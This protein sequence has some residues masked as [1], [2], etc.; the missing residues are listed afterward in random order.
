MMIENDTFEIYRQKYAD[1]H[2][3]NNTWGKRLETL[4]RVIPDGF[5]FIQ[6]ER[7]LTWKQFDG[8][9]NRL[10]NLFL[11]LGIEKEDRI[12]IMGFNSIE[13]VE[14]YFAASKIGAVPVNVNARFVPDEVRYILEDSDSVAV[15]LESDAADRI[16]Q[17]SGYLPLLKHKIVWGSEVSTDMLDYGELMGGY[18]DTRPEFDWNVT[19]EDFSFLFYTGG[20]TGYPKGTVWDGE[21]RVRGLDML[22]ASAYGSS[23]DLMNPKIR[24]SMGNVDKLTMINKLSNMFGTPMI[25]RAIG[26]SIRTLVACPLFHGTAYQANFC[27]IGS[28]G[29]TSVYLSTSHPFNA[30]ELW[31]TV[32]E[33]K[34]NSILIVGD[35]FAIPMVEELEKGDYDL[36]SLNSIVSSGVIWS[37]KIKKRMLELMQNVRLMDALGSSEVSSSFSQSSSSG[38]KE[39][40]KL[41]VKLTNEGPNPCRCIN[42]MTGED[43]KPGERGEFIYGGYMA[44]G[45]WKDPEKTARA[46]RVIDDKRWFFVGDEGT[47]DEGGYFHFIGRGPTVINTGGEKVYPEEVEEIIKTNPNVRDAAVVGIPDEK[48][49]EAVTAIVELKADKRATEEEVIEFCRGKMSGYKKPKHV[50]FVDKVPRAAA[51]KLERK[52]LKEMAKKEL[53]KSLSNL[54]PIP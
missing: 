10:A 42:P 1:G 13:W 33:K 52:P 3:S 53:G 34:V 37:P 32:E 31:E 43:V 18:P 5:A 36:S 26:S 44:L 7:E 6:G 50:L 17:I 16:N 48:W 15:V 27:N 45:Y 25:Y 4:A 28:A 49:G 24:K 35:A 47:V 14:T 2:K 39:I 30:K 23:P 46:W 12:A 41:N 11:D 9:V 51:G 21:M 22:L 54:K 19:N 38:E 20:T 29:L 40:Q 8:R